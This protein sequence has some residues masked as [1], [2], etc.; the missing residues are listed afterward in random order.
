MLHYLPTVEY[1]P[2]SLS[3]SVQALAMIHL[4]IHSSNEYKMSVVLVNQR[5]VH[6]VQSGDM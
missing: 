2:I 6:F 5:E 4:W 3:S 1:L